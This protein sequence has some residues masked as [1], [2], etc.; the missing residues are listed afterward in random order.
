MI[1]LTESHKYASFMQG[2]DRAL[3]KLLLKYLEHMG[4]IVSTLKKKCLTLAGLHQGL[5]HYQ[6]RQKTQEFEQSIRPYFIMAAEEANAL[7]TR[8]QKTTYLLSYIGQA[9]GIA[10]STGKLRVARPSASDVDTRGAALAFSRLQRKVVDA[11]QVSMIATDQ[12]HPF[13]FSR[14]EKA[15]PKRTSSKPKRKILAKMQEADRPGLNDSFLSF[16]IVEPDEWDQI[17]EDYF[18]EEF[19]PNSP[20]RTPYSRVFYDES[21]PEDQGRYEWELENE[22]TEDFVQQVRDGEN[23]AANDQGITDFQ[24]IA[25]IDSKTCD[26]CCSPRDGLTSKE[27][28]EKI[29]SGEIPDACNGKILPGL[30]RFCRCR[31]VP[32]TDDL[33]ETPRSNLMSFEDFLD[34]KAS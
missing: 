14:I 25:V 1:P 9:E 19:P 23:D 7:L 4:P 21:N 32:M 28:E 6:F 5:D 20:N 3:E 10:R 27:I 30:H 24:F 26:D 13:D 22:V 15:F 29:A 34:S 31:S 11:F 33:N 17:L 18:A 2:R 8:L 12:D 16:G